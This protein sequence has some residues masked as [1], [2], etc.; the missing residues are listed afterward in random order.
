MQ[1]LQLDFKRV[2]PLDKRSITVTSQ[3]N[4]PL[5]GADS[6]YYPFNLI[7][8]GKYEGMT[9]AEWILHRELVRKQ[10]VAL[11]SCKSLYQ[12]AAKDYPRG[13]ASYWNNFS[14]GGVH[15]LPESATP[16]SLEELKKMTYMEIVQ[17][18]QARNKQPTSSDETVATTQH[19]H[20]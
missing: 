6:P 13:E 17:E 16:F 3:N 4:N 15:L 11:Y 20:G 9:D 8:Y 5:P 14:V 10:F 1:R 2:N 19:R 7:R 12:K 18:M